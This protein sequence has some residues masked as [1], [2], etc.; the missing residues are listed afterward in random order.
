M[1][2]VIFK[3]EDH[4]AGASPVAFFPTAPWSLNPHECTCYA[5]VGQ[6]SAASVD[7]AASLKPAT[8][9]QYAPLLRE[10]KG[11]GYSDLRIVRRFT[12]KHLTTRRATIDVHR[13][14]Q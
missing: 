14:A 8:E 3:M 10:L 6:H 12:A 4:G 2:P 13:G 5:H 9:E 1:T 7:Y 11:R